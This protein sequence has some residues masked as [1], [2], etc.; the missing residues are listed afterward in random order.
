[1]AQG[2]LASTQS[3]GSES[4]NGA[5]TLTGPI[6]PL[7]LL[8]KNRKPRIREYQ[9]QPAAKML[10]RDVRSAG[11][12]VSALLR[13]G[14]GKTCHLDDMGSWDWKGDAG[15]HCTKGWARPQ[16]PAQRSRNQALN[17]LGSIPGLGR[18][19]GEG[20]CYPLVFWPGEFHGL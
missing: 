8:Q 13:W 19:P 7:Q 10:G 17:S 11:A 15:I 2:S 20:K 9:N 5:H 6:F 14:Q 12:V 1:M 16:K 4:H 18:Y 3:I